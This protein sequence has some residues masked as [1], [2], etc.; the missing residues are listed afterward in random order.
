MTGKIAD[1]TK[2]AK[3]PGGISLFEENDPNTYKSTFEILQE[4]S[5]IWDDLTDKNRAGLLE[6]LFG[7]R[8][9]QIG[10]A[11]LSNFDQAKSAIETMTNSAG[12]AER[13]MEKITQS[14]EYRMN[15]LGQT[16]VGVAQ[17]LFQTDDIKAV[18]SVLQFFSDA[19][20]GITSKLGLFGTVSLGGF[21]STI[22][23]VVKAVGRPKLTGFNNVPTY[24][25][26]V[27]RNEH[28]A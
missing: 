28:A 27:T 7:K 3:T 15:A 22:N 6:A 11:I 19:I 1:L 2:T 16:W 13:E 25:L 9:A 26:V 23:Q 5:E 20:D 21:V 12:S 10:A 14:L 18:V 17:N 24:A 4:I 8:Q